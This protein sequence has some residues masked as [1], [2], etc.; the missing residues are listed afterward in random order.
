MKR[1]TRRIGLAM[2]ATLAAAQVA[3][4]RHDKEHARHFVDGFDAG[5]PGTNWES[6]GVPPVLDTTAG[7]PAPSITWGACT[8]SGGA[9]VVNDTFYASR[10]LVASFEFAVRG[11]ADGYAQVRFN[12]RGQD[13]P[14]TAAALVQP[15]E[16]GNPGFVGFSAG[17]TYAQSP[18]PSDGAFHRAEFTLDGQ[19]GHGTWSLDGNPISVTSIFRPTIFQAYFQ[20]VD[21]STAAEPA[22]IPVLLDNVDIESKPLRGPLT[23]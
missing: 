4:C 23:F 12:L 10:S 18:L 16:Q 9:A 5:F 19:N 20:C 1:A 2:A 22:P 8:G 21:G 17:G 13:F 3:G 7:D 14:D 11:S 15:D 6:S